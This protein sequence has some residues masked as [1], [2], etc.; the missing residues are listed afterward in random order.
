MTPRTKD[1]LETAVRGAFRQVF[2]L[3]TVPDDAS[4]A[5]I[6]NWDSLNHLNLMFALEAALGIEI[7]TQEYADMLTYNMIVEILSERLKL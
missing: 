2:R 6:P 5:N 4:P 1:E 3:E 7:T